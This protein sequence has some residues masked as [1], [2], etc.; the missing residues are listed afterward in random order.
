MGRA[1]WTWGKEATLSEPL[2]AKTV[3]NL[4]YNLLTRVLVF[5]LSSA[6]GIILARN[7]S[8]SDYGI[9]G[10]AM[11]FMGFLGQFSDLGVTS[12]AIQ[13]ETLLENELYTAFTLKIALGL[14]LFFMSF[15]FAD[16]SQWAFDNPA[17][18]IVVIV[19]AIGFLID[20]LGFLS[21]TTLTRELKFKRLTIPQIGSQIAA[22]AVAITTVY[23]GFRYWS[24]VFADLATSV[25]TVAI[26]FALC[27]VPLKFKWDP[28]SARKLL[29]FGSNLFFAGLMTFALFNA[30]NFV[31]GA[32]GGAAVLGFY[33]IAFNW[34][35][36]ATNLIA[37]AIHK[38]LLSTFSRV[39]N[40]AE[41]LRRGYLTILEYVG[42][43][44]ILANTLLLIA[45]KD[46]LVLVLGAGTGKWLPA[47]VALD[48]FCLYGT[49]RA[50]LEPVGS[51]I[52]AI[53]RPAL[54]FKSNA[55]VTTLQLACLYPALRYF[56]IAGV[57]VVVTVSYAAQFFIYFPALRKELGIAFSAAFRAVRPALL[58]GLV[59]AAFGLAFDRFVATSW[60]SLAA[61]L[62]LGPCLYLVT[63]GLV[64]R[65]R[66][67]KEAREIIGTVLLKPSESRV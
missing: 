34:G 62:T 26:V 46:L 49:I 1:I 50:I 3:V 14:L 38:I 55:I 25:A 27:P 40:D 33:S 47:L 13:K 43:A 5:I 19:L 29:K 11:I 23:L 37:Q 44:A 28:E 35:T 24:I 7:L 10:F 22:S 60:L 58:S 18:K 31:I 17:V 12:S 20:C 36:K 66:M 67:I 6:T 2:K 4:S 9:V 59:L 57:A 51:V 48:I 45:S 56:G 65:W 30:D 8:S 54:L 53:G 64:T 61:K 63:Y 21:R 15:I 16:L 39:Q 42:F 41:R 52:I 32:V